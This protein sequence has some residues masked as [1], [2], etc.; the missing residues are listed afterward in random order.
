MVSLFLQE[1]DSEE[2]AHGE[3]PTPSQSSLKR[4]S[5]FR[6]ADSPNSSPHHP[7]GRFSNSEPEPP[8]SREEVMQE[9]V[10]VHN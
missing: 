9:I 3:S 2:S 8:K 5:R 4:K 1:S 10:S 6:N 7:S